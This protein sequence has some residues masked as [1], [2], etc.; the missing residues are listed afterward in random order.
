M[1]D[2]KRLELDANTDDQQLLAQ[3]V[4][5]GGRVGVDR[6]LQGSHFCAEEGAQWTLPG[7]WNLQCR[8]QS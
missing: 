1:P 6:G 8:A 4:G 2:R 5:A 7:E 3:V